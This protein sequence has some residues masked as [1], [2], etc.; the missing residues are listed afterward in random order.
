MNGGEISGNNGIKD[1][2]AI[3]GYLYSQF[4]LNDGLIIDNVCE[5]SNSG[6]G[7]YMNQARSLVIND[8]LISGNIG[9][10]GAGVST[11]WVDTISI[12]GGVIINNSAPGD[13]FRDKD[14][15]INRQDGTQLSIKGGYMGRFEVNQVWGNYN[16]VEGGFF[17]EPTITDYLTEG[18]IAIPVGE[19]VT[20]YREG[21][22]YGVYK[23]NTNGTDI[24][25]DITPGNPAYDQAPIE[26]GIDF[27]AEGI[28][29]SLCAVYAYRTDTIEP[30]AYGLP[31]DAGPY[32]VMS[33]LL[34][35]NGKWYYGQTPFDI[36]ID[37]GEWPGEKMATG[38]IAAGHSDSI[39]L[40]EIPE[41]AYFGTPSGDTRILDAH[42]ADGYLYYTGSD[43]IEPGEVYTLLVPVGEGVNYRIFAILVQLTGN[44]VSGI[45]S[46]DG[47]NL[48]IFT[49]P[50]QLHIAGTSAPATVYNLQGRSVYRGTDR[51]ITLP[52]G[53]YIVQV[54]DTVRK[55]V[56]R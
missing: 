19:G 25:L 35:K 47:D 34:S 56:V 43:D 2:G 23:R 9:Y 41:G 3:Y 39:A 24:A 13:E 45:Q 29:D 55:A 48:R 50:G 17:V 52:G 4:T 8:G 46:V 22:P 31:V 11:N 28:P 26:A 16:V 20:G 37:K 6:G 51:T 49:T 54:G 38:M 30:F 42:I 15:F 12:T 1:A 5:G 36:T 27:T 14:I 18:A 40:P 53:A 32:H 10:F 21:F 44:E 7:I 33:T